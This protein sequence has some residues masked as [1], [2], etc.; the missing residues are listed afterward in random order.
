MKPTA[1]LAAMAIASSGVN[2]DC[3]S[4]GMIGHYGSWLKQKISA[5]NTDRLSLA[6]MAIAGAAKESFV[7][8]E[9]RTYCMQEADGLKWDFSI[10][11][12]GY[13]AMSCIVDLALCFLLQFRCSNI[14]L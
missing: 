7:G 11:V 10:K 3:F 5:L 12:L 8:E 14:R 13:A 6:C 9:V 2:A 1:F 4:N